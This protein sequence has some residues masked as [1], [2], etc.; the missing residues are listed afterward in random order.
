MGKPRKRKV[1]RPSKFTPEVRAAIL[2]SLS[3]GC[4]MEG[5]ADAAGINVDSLYTWLARGRRLG[6]GPFHAFSDAVQVALGESENS[7][8]AMIRAAGPEDWKAALALLERRWP[9]RWALGTQIRAEAEK[10][11]SAMLARLQTVLPAETFSA[12]VAALGHA[13]TA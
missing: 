13:V 9:S 5:A 2:A 12:V 3:Y 6:R 1:G 8:V 11:V 4:T 10:Q 7:L